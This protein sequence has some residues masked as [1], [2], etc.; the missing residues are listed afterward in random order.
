VNGIVAVSPVAV[1]VS[2]SVPAPGVS[3]VR[4]VLSKRARSA[5]STVTVISSPGAIEF[6]SIDRTPSGPPTIRVRDLS[7]ATKLTGTGR[8]STNTAP[9]RSVS[10]ATQLV[11]ASRPA[12]ASAGAP[13]ANARC[14]ATLSNATG[15]SDVGKTESR[16][17]EI[18][19]MKTCPTDRSLL[20]MM[21]V[22]L[23]GLMVTVC[24]VGSTL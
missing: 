23:P 5:G 13:S 18:L 9:G 3:P 15:G 4:A 6:R 10:V 1:V 20:M 21:S 17:E 11:E 8:E 22:V 24:G 14:I 12:C 7:E 2:R 16:S 19:W